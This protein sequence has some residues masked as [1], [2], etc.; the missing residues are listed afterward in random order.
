MVCAQEAYG[1]LGLDEVVL[2]P[3]GQAPHREIESDPGAETRARLCDAAVEGVEWLTV[4]R[5]EVERGGRAYTVDTLAELTQGR[6]ETEYVFVLGADQAR[7]LADWREPG[8][9]LE[10]AELAVAERSGASVGDVRD[11]VAAL[12][13]GGRLTTFAMPRIDV[14]STDIRARIATGRPYRFLVPE[15]VAVLIEREGFYR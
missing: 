2:M 14:S 8:R 6:P 13:G 12:G 1:Q 11:T 3:V 5:V 10:L 4:S 7:R 15:R 9:V